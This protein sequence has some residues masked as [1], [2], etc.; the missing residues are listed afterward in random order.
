MTISDVRELSEQLEK[1]SIKAKTSGMS[2][3]ALM[4]HSASVSIEL[5]AA[6]HEQRHLKKK[7]ESLEVNAESVLER[8]DFKLDS[9]FERLLKSNQIK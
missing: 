6:I 8:I 9:M 7:L 1:E 5:M 2:D 4:L 3:V